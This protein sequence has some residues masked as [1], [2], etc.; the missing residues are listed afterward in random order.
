MTKLGNVFLLG[1]SYTTFKGY[2]PDGHAAYYSESEDSITD[3]TKVEDTWW[4]QVLARTDS[5]LIL[6]SS[7]S[8]STICNTGYSGKDSSHSSFISRL[9]TLIDEG[10]FAEN[11]IDT[12]IV[13]GGTNDAWADSPI[14]EFK[15]EGQTKD[16]LYSFRPAVCYL[17]SRLAALGTRVLFVVNTELKEEVPD[18]IK[19]VCRRYSFEF[20]QLKKI[21]K[22]QGHPGIAGMKKIA[23]QVI[24]YFEKN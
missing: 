2:I 18:G 12:V 19:E 16:D 15:W 11:K 10:F 20:L 7:W 1:D 14:G 9:D 23:E 4:N 17:G 5:S 22:I 24:E 3:A 8:G 13:L 6:N 21:D